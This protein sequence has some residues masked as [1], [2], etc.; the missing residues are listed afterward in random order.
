MQPATRETSAWSA[1]VRRQGAPLI[2]RGVVRALS[3]ATIS[4]RLAARLIE[5]PF[6]EG[7]QFSVGDVLAKFECSRTEAEAR[8]A[9]A[10][11]IA[12]SK[13]VETNKELDKFEAIGKNELLISIAQL[14]RAQAESDALATLLSECVLKAPFNGKVVSRLARVHEAVE[15]GSPL[16]KI[17][18]T[19][20][21]ELDLIV[22]SLW[23]SWL[24]VGHDF[25]FLVDETG[26][27]LPAKVTRLYPNVDPISKTIRI[28]AV[29]TANTDFVLPGMSGTGNFQNNIAN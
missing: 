26:S 25:Q 28:V 7:N 15:P 3:E 8:A 21:V 12:Q 14:E 9:A 16:I 23:L 17:V 1:E 27:T 11:V 13:Q 20:G 18:G 2:A 5:L 29:F 24:K 22:P 10:V 19:D 4:S 6:A